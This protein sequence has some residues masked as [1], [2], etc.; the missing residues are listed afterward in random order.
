[1]ERIKIKETLMDIFTDLSEEQASYLASTGDDINILITRVLDKNIDKIKIDIKDIVRKPKSV[2]SCEYNFNY[3]EVFD[4][5]Y[6]INIHDNPSELRKRASKLYEEASKC[7]LKAHTHEYEKCRS[8]FGI[9]SDN[10]RDE[11]NALNRKAALIIMRKALE[12][13]GPIDLHGL[14]VNEALGFVK[15]IYHFYNF[16]DIRFITGQHYKSLKIRPAITEW[17]VK[18]NYTVVDEGPVIRVF[19]NFHI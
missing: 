3:P 12:S 19:K 5:K 15:D 4:N 2:Q 17:L 9:Q 16:K 7:S 10:I 1:M 8:H 6:R 18:H 14:H 13:N 11:A